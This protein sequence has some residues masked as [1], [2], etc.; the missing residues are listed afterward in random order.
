[1][2]EIRYANRHRVERAPQMFDL[3]VDELE[4]DGWLP[5]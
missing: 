1:M 4:S 2:K 3:I 5:A